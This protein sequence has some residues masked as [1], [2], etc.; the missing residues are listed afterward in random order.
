MTEHSRLG[1]TMKD[2]K[3]ILLK[4]E[5]KAQNVPMLRTPRTHEEVHRFLER[6]D[7]DEGGTSNITSFHFDNRTYFL[8][9]NP[10][11]NELL[12][13]FKQK[14]PARELLLRVAPESFLRTLFQ[15]SLTKCHH[16]P[17]F[18]SKDDFSF[19]LV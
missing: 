16:T 3:E 10:K 5:L 9:V 7:N 12:K 6:L 8:K 4:D 19:S 2:V 11:L 17:S 1:Q 14:G 15:K 13:D 18:C